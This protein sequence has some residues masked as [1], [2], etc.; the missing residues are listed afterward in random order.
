MTNDHL[1]LSHWSLIGHWSLVI[2][3]CILLACISSCRHNS[4]HGTIARMIRP[5]FILTIL[6]L[7]ASFASAAAPPAAPAASIPPDANGAEKALS[8]SPRHGEWV[9]IALP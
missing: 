4:R 5:P 7:A 3:A 1:V 9:D 2:G 6:L 8:S